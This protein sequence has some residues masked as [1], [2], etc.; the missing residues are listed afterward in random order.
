MKSFIQLTFIRCYPH[1]RNWSYTV[2]ETVPLITELSAYSTISLLWWNFLFLLSHQP[3]TYLSANEVKSFFFTNLAIYFYYFFPLSVLATFKLFQ[4]ANF[5]IICFFHF[6][7]LRMN[8]LQMYPHLLLSHPIHYMTSEFYPF[9][10]L[11][12][13]SP[14]LLSFPSFVFAMA[15]TQS[16]R[17]WH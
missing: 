8:W 3:W 13:P 16:H 2:N 14:L 17:L 4:K 5:R 1:S 11:F 10:S 12:L 9:L 15:L 7:S 6:I